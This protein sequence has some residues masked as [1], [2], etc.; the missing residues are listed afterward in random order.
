MSGGRYKKNSYF[1]ASNGKA[2]IAG[3]RVISSHEGLVVKWARFYFGFAPG[4]DGLTWKKSNEH[5][6]GKQRETVG[7]QSTQS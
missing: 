1:L 6:I 4:V 2:G 7:P 3:T 5:G